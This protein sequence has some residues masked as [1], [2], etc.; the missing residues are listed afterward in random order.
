MDS[1]IDVIIP[2]YNTPPDYLKKLFDSLLAQQFPFWRAIVIDDGSDDET[3]CYL[4][5]W[6]K[7]DNRILIV[8]QTNAGPSESRNNGLRISKSSFV[9][10]C[11]SDD[12]FMPD[13]FQNAICSIEKYNA[14][15][16][17]ASTADIKNGKTVR[18]RKA[19]DGLHVFNKPAEIKSI[20]RHAISAIPLSETEKL[21]DTYLARVYPKVIKREI[22]C[23]SFFQPQVCISEDGLYS[24]ETINQ[25]KVIIVDSRIGYSINLRDSSLSRGKAPEIVMGD[26]KKFLKVFGEDMQKWFE[27]GCGDAYRIRLLMVFLKMHNEITKMKLSISKRIAY[28]NE[29]F[30]LYPLDN[31]LAH[32]DF[33][34]FS[35]K[36]NITIH[37]LLIA[38]ILKCP[39]R[40][41]IV[42]CIVDGLFMRFLL[43]VKKKRLCLQSK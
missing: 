7:K 13:F 32:V 39:R 28:Y 37:K 2:V 14:D 16:Y 17:I 4:D 5:E 12:C 21:N 26:L 35:I 41:K 24:F 29:V 6:A 33:S 38:K 11:D 43:E 36:K 27:A 22:A 10:F 30:S 31:E 15:M 42:L 25:C 34:N 9:S 3:A 19:K 1:Q 40:M 23:N 8:H 18:T 20:V